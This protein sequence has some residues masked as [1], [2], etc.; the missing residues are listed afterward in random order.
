[1]Y[2]NFDFDLEFLESA[3]EDDWKEM[4]RKELGC[5]RKTTR[6]LQLQWDWYNYCVKVR[7]QDTTSED[8]TLVGVCKTVK[9]KV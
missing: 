7:C 5:T 1:M 8:T 3:V 6:V 2:S 9:G 4:A